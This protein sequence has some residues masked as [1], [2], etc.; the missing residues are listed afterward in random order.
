VSQRNS[1]A[2]PAEAAFYN[3]DLARQ[4]TAQYGEQFTLLT[5]PVLP[6]NGWIGNA[7][8]IEFLPGGRF[9]AAA[10]PVRSGG[11]S[12]LVVHPR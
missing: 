8:G 2:A 6:L 12:A 7:T 1:P 5:G 10:E 11:G 4:L 9:R 3:S